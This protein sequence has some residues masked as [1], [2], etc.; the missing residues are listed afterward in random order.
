MTIF[1]KL[2]SNSGH[3]SITDK[4]FKTRRCP[5][6]RGLTIVL[7]CHKKVYH[8]SVKKNLNELRVEFWINRGTSYDNGTVFKLQ[9]SQLFCSER[10]ITWKFDLDGGPWWGGFWERLVGMAKKCF[11]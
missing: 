5:L 1:F 3:L 4:F 9:D 8:N 2:P 6:F 7:R 10:G 11:K